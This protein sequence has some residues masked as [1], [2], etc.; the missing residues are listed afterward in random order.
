MPLQSAKAILVAVGA[1]SHPTR[2]SH[3]A[4]S[5]VAE[6]VDASEHGRLVAIDAMRVLVAMVNRRPEAAPM[7]DV[8]VR[9]ALNHGIDRERFVA[10]VL[11][12]YGSPLASLAPA[13]AK[14]HADGIE[15][16]AY[17]PERGRSLL[18]EAG[19]PQG[20]PLRVAA[21]P[22]LADMARWLADAYRSSL[23]LEVELVLPSAEQVPAAE[24][25]IVEKRLELPWDIH[26]HAWFDLT[27]DVPAAVMH[28]EFFHTV[29]AFRTGDPVPEFDEL[30]AEYKTQVEE[31]E[32]DRIGAQLDRLVYDQA[33]SVFIASPQALYAVNKNVSFVA[34]RATF[35]LAETEVNDQHW[36]RRT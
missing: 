27:A 4:A 12:G 7:Q 20:R 22:P 28:R 1:R 34:H 25:A 24:R 10:E 15:P 19:Y 33:L 6:R 21:P 9:K 13:W 35:E 29:G 31:R 11:K 3:A 8:R 26:L 17:D 18:T 36:S 5:H 23:G 14:G 32:L 30:F 16:Y 2:A